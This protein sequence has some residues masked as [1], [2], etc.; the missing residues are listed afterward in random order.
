MIKELLSEYEDEID[1]P[2]D[3]LPGA[4]ADA[5]NENFMEKDLES[6]SVDENEDNEEEFE[7]KKEET[8]E[9]ADLVE[10]A[11]EK[12]SSLKSELLFEKKK[13][14][15]MESDLEA[16]KMKA[17]QEIQIITDSW[18]GT[19]RDLNK[20]LKPIKDKLRNDLKELKNKQKEQRK[21]IKANINAI[22]S[23]IINAEYELKLITNKGKLQ[24]ILADD[25]IMG[26]LKERWIDTEIS[27][28]LDYPIFMAVSERGG[29]NNSGYYEYLIDEDGGIIE[30]G[31][32]Q[33]IID[34]DLVNLNLKY[35][36]LID[37]SSLTDDE[38]CIAEAFVQFAQKSGFD[39]WR[40]G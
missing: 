35:E 13:L 27:K 19:K 9:I 17:D 1:I 39:F 25:E 11:E 12:I 15:N 38:I 29:K 5:I 18:T 26:A 23:G 40:E 31:D 14:V 33:P 28:R 30:F 32:G 10:L 20:E 24:L 3:K 36:D 34:Q 8:K 4:I 21:K 22:E 37:A 7:A 2:D 6:D 16:L